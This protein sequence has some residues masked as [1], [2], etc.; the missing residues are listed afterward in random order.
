MP[1]NVFIRLYQQA[2]WDR[3][4][5]EKFDSPT[6]I[7]TYRYLNKTCTRHMSSYS[8]IKRGVDWQRWPPV[9]MASPLVAGAARCLAARIP[10]PWPAQPAVW[11]QLRSENQ[12]WRRQLYNAAET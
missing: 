8:I 10:T 4:A 12:K 2:S 11:R 5:S 3:V 6:I 9:A 1:R 7:C